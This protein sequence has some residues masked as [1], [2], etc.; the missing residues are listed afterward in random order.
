[1]QERC[2]TPHLNKQLLC[3]GDIRLLDVQAD[4]PEDVTVG[5]AT[6]IRFTLPSQPDLPAEMARKGYIFGDRTIGVSLNPMRIPCDIEKV[7]RLPVTLQPSLAYR[8]AMLRIACDAFPYDRRFHILPNCDGAV[9]CCVLRDWIDRLSDVLICEYKGELAGFLSLQ[10]AENDAKIIHLAATDARY[11]MLGAA[12]ALYGQA[13]LQSKA[14]G[15]K[16]IL[17]RVSTQNPAV[18]SLYAFFGGVF[19]D[20]MDV[21]LKAVEADSS[22]NNNSSIVGGAALC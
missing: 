18:M 10:D 19:A 15:A 7:C 12:T 17:G 20:P 16:K 2:C 21:Y 13:I 6:H 8:E 1:M 3:Y 9:A 22:V 14:A 4:H 5:E 11:R